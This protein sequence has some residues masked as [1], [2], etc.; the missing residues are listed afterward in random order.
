MVLFLAGSSFGRLQRVYLL[1]FFCNRFLYV[2]RHRAI[3]L[4]PFLSGGR[5]ARTVFPCLKLDDPGAPVAILDNSKAFPSGIRTTCLLHEQAFDTRFQCCAY[6]N[7]IT[8]KMIKSVLC[9]YILPGFVNMLY[10]NTGLC[11][12]TARNIL[13]GTA[14]IF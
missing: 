9:N 5:E 4:L 2:G 12:N 6:H 13:T 10:R 1:L 7:S 3:T 8:S 11:D 14:K